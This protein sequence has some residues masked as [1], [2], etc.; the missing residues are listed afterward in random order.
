MKFFVRSA[1]WAGFLIAAS[2]ANA[3]MPARDATGPSPYK[4]S[5]YKNV[6]DFDGPYSVSPPPPPEAYGS[7]YE[8]YGSR[9]YAAPA[10]LPPTEVYAVL[11]E[12][13][14]SPLGI[15]RQRGLVYVITALD[16]SGDDGR[17]VIDA[18][19]GRIL[20]FIPAYHYGA[21]FDDD[22]SLGYGRPPAYGPPPSYGPS[23]YGPQS[24]LTPVPEPAAVR[25]VPRPPAPIPHVASRVPVPAPKPNPP[26]AQPQQ[27]ASVQPRPAE[28]ASAAPAA[29]PPPAAPATVGAAKPS[30]Q[31]QPTQPMPQVQGLD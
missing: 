23:V 6:S 22:E 30:L 31:L 17:L 18:R 5:P 8:G 27:S 26:A 11:R 9:Y 4:Q 16:R 25:G 7:G 20:R 24:A 2:A 21:R 12:N 3:Q 15:P 1:A 10:L 14:F 19:D 29:A 13:G 28:S